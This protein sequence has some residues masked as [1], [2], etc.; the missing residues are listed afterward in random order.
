MQTFTHGTSFGSKKSLFKSVFSPFYTLMKMYVQM[1]RKHHYEMVINGK[2]LDQATK[3]EIYDFRLSCYQGKND[4]LIPKSSAEIA[5]EKLYD[6]YAYH[7][8]VRDKQGILVA[9]ARFLPYPFEMCSI[10]LPTDLK[11]TQFNNYLE[12]SRLVTNRPGLGIGK[13]LLIHAGLWAILDTYYDGFL[14][15]CRDKN[16]QLF[17][18]FGLSKL[19]TFQIEQR[20]GSDY[21]LIKA[22]FR[23]ISKSTM[24]F[25][26]VNRNPLAQLALSLKTPSLSKRLTRS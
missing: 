7:A 16:L 23:L 26:A 6:D 4:Y 25:F 14:A 20:K 13:R 22:D 2:F 11:L 3:N 12:I 15:I 8:L 21:N 17:S 10:G 24:K 18:Y 9:V 5:K 1:D 19:S